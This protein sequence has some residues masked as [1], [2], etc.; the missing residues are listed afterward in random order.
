VPTW[1]DGNLE[2][3]YELHGDVGDP[4]VFVHGSLGDHR[5]WSRLLPSLAQSLQ[6]LVY[7]RRGYGQSR[8]PARTQAVR[9]D[10]ADLAALLEATEHFPAHL[11]A[12][13]Y[14]GAVALRLAADRP[15]LV[16]SIS[17]HEPP[18][19]GLLD[20]DPNWG[21]EAARWRKLVET[22]RAAI[23]AGH[24]EEAARRVVNWFS[25]RE[26]AWE[27]LHPEIRREAVDYMDRWREEYSDPEAIRP[28]AP[29]L[30]EILIPGLVT[31][32]A[33]SPPLMQLIAHALAG[34]LRNALE[35]TIP[36]V[37]HVPQITEPDQ[38]AGILAMFLL[39]RNVPTV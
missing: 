36:G 4:A 29:V 31:V 5:T 37:G 12:H 11:V 1:K 38:Y 16:R 14:A 17:M 25:T 9:E 8:G 34:G 32:G 23:A 27:R 6:V 22:T 20:A 28:P 15:E 10:A 3:Y 13:S 21:G 33:Q 24:A 26:E 7:D 35:R 2:L 30:S 19:I 39:E 18:L